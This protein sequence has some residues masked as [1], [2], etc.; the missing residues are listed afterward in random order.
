MNIFEQLDLLLIEA[1]KKMS[2]I[3]IPIHPEMENKEQGEI[4]AAEKFLKLFKRLKY[5][6]GSGG[7][8]IVDDSKP[9]IPD[10][11]IDPMMKEPPTKS[12]DKTFKKNKLHGWDEKSDEKIGKEVEVDNGDSDPND[13]FDDFDCDKDTEFDENYTDGIDENGDSSGENDVDDTLEDTIDDAF[14]DLKSFNEED[15]DVDIDDESA[16]NW[17]DEDEG[18][19]D[20]NGYR[21]D[22]GGDLKEPLGT[23][24]PGGEPGGTK[25]PGGN[26]GTR[27]P[28]GEPG[29]N[30]GTKEPGNGK[31]KNRNEKIEDLKKS[32]KD[33]DSQDFN[34]KIEELKNSKDEPDINELPGGLIETPTDDIIRKEMEK[35]GLSK[36]D[37]DRVNEKKSKVIDKTDEDNVKKEAI[38]SYD[39]FRREHGG[40]GSALY[41]K[42]AKHS[43][44]Q[45]FGEKNW[46]TLLEL[47]LKGKSEGEG[48]LK[49]SGDNG[50]KAVNKNRISFGDYVPTIGAPSKSSIQKIYCFLDFSGSVQKSLTSTFLGSIINMCLSDEL[51]YSEIHVY[52]FGERL[53]KPVII[54]EELIMEYFNE[55]GSD[56]YLKTLLEDIWTFLS[57]KEKAGFG[58]ENF[59]EVIERINEI[60]DDEEQS[61]FL[62][63]GDGLWYDNTL[64]PI[65]VSDVID[66][67]DYLEDV[68]VLAYYDDNSYEWKNWAEEAF[69]NA[70]TTLI[71][72]GVNK[73][74]VILTKVNNISSKSHEYI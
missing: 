6:S 67:K 56:M 13:F 35:A 71:S 15:E 30:G 24:E 69:I 74:Y 70:I 16:A 60:K 1:N 58:T 64:G 17:G 7:D 42:Y 19:D 46:E 49:Y 33:G 50:I 59:K 27:E 41:S 8:G 12:K 31:P 5:G 55:Q 28:G 21:T 36:K 66:D 22:G 4:A 53:T 14:D 44:K 11:I 23:R 10:D 3:E 29:G 40:K 51:N 25:E 2:E 68:C 45:K 73:E 34:D 9:E 61:I 57:V 39:K 26:G 52:G 47:F 62:I 63:F 18:I 54:N 37:I 32:I 38:E 65:C 48:G 20:G 43:I 72:S